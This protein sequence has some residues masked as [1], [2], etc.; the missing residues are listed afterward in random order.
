MSQ[1][2]KHLL[3]AEEVA[4][5]RGLLNIQAEIVTA[6]ETINMYENPVYAIQLI[7]EF[8]YNQQKAVKEGAER[9]LQAKQYVTP[10]K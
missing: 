4:I 1:N 5:L 10:N 2:V 7:P 3:T 9:R 8:K 6:Q